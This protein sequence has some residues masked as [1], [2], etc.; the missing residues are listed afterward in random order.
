MILST[1]ASNR[2]LN[3]HRPSDQIVEAVPPGYVTEV[4]SLRHS[5]QQEGPKPKDRF[6]DGE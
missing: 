1:T 6:D 5:N 3:L 4:M 2:D